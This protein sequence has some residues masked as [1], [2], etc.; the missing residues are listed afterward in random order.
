MKTRII[1]DIADSIS[2]VADHGIVSGIQRVVIESWLELSQNNDVEAI[3][4][5]YYSP[6]HTFLLF[7][8]NE[9][10]ELAKLLHQ[11]VDAEQNQRVAA[12]LWSG[13]KKA[14]PYEFGN[15]DVLLS[16]GATWAQPLYFNA[17]A[18]AKRKGAAIVNLIYDLIP[19][20]DHSFPHATKEPFRIYVSEISLISDRAPCISQA[21]RFDFERFTEIH[22][23]SCP[24]GGATGLPGG[25]SEQ[26]RTQSITP[27]EALAGLQD[28]DFVLIV[29]TIESRKEHVVALKAWIKLLN[30][31]PADQLP[32]LVF[33]GRWGWNVR[34]LID[35]WNKNIAIQSKVHFLTE[36][37]VD[38][39]VVHLYKNCLFTIYPSRIEGWGLPVTESLDFGKVVVTTNTSSLPE[40]GEGLAIL[41]EQGSVDEL[42]DICKDLIVNKDYRTRLEERIKNERT[43]RSWK[44]F[45]DVLVAESAQAQS[46]KRSNEVIEPE[47]GRE[48]GLLSFSDLDVGH[49][50][51]LYMESLK[52]RR[53]LPFTNQ[54]SSIEHHAKALLMTS[55]TFTQLTRFGVSFESMD[56]SRM[57]LFF[58]SPSSS[59]FT[60]LVSAYLKGCDPKK[61]SAT[62][63]RNPDGKIQLKHKTVLRF[64]FDLSHETQETSVLSIDFNLVGSGKLF[65]SSFLF[66]DGESHSFDEEISAA[67]RQ[68]ENFGDVFELRDLAVGR[69]EEMQQSISWKITKP[70]RIIHRKILKF[71]R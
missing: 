23:L 60:I 27:T 67:I 39:D 17:A 1:V 58:R 55:G 12:R 64:D 5:G 37:V 40:A 52:T 41:F 36:N 49:S 6:R 46:S 50:A 33:A 63:N 38:S 7:K 45:S 25:F 44:N 9:V 69:A 66:L 51:K 35:E 70:L 2:F 22:G 13:L 19:G 28:K 29:G 11:G 68:F 59:R 24:P 32:E 18:A 42:S 65:I 14:D 57:E 54:I 43:P 10:D 71:S 26:A 20:F 34:E 3:P 61:V 21:T 16:M 31:L 56:K 4:V 30:Q 15:D 48:Y 8:K 53:S 47:F 62:S